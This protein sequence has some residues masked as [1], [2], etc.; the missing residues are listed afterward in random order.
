MDIIK[1]GQIP[2]ETK[3]EWTCKTCKSEI[4]SKKSEGTLYHDQR[5]GDYV[6]CRCPVCARE[7]YI[8]SNLYK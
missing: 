2:S 6:K 7:N 8:A 3:A 5:D 4:R 1:R